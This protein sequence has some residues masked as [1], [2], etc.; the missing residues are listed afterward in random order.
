[1]AEVEFGTCPYPFSVQ[2]QKFQHCFLPMVFLFVIKPEKI[3][4]TVL[5]IKNQQVGKRKEK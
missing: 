2:V 3:W 5:Q 4:I 1:M